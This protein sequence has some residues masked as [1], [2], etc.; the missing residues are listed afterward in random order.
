MNRYDMSKFDNHHFSSKVLEDSQRLLVRFHTFV[1]KGN[2]IPTDEMNLRYF[3]WSKDHLNRCYQFLK[4]AKVVDYAR[5]HRRT[6]LKFLGEFAYLN[7][8][9]IKP[10]K[11]R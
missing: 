5:N 7:D 6:T 4:E 11:K 3:N 2:C 10:Q 1:Q 8:F 9:I